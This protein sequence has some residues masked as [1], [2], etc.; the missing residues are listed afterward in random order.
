MENIFYYIIGGALTVASLIV[1]EPKLDKNL[2]TGKWIF[3]YTWNYERK[4]IQL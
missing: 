3:W 2:E 1:F 4:Y